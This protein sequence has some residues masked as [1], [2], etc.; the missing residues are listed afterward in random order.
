VKRQAGFFQLV[1]H[2]I[3]VR[4]RLATAT[5]LGL[6]GFLAAAGLP[7][8]KRALLAWDIGAGLYLVLA[9][10]MMLRP[11]GGVEKMK[12]RSR[13]QDDGARI[14]LVLTLTATVASLAAIVLEL[15]RVQGLPDDDH[16]TLGLVLA[17]ATIFI[18]WCFVH[19]AFAL[20]YAHEFYVDRGPSGGPGLEFPGGAPPD[21][22]DFLYFSFVIGTTSQTADVSIVSRAMRRLAL[23]HGIVAFVF[24]TTLLALTIN[25]AAGL[26]GH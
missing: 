25:I 24:N 12:W 21:Y 16:R 1:F 7:E 17:G 10:A 9:W 11:G 15:V 22:L 2:Q 14:V 8:P 20:H 19:T 5:V 3:R 23:L 13:L 26:I 18:S 6:V 4:P